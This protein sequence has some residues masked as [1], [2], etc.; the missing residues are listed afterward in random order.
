MAHIY[1]EFSGKKQKTPKAKVLPLTDENLLSIARGV[2]YTPARLR[3][4]M[5]SAS[6]KN[7]V[8]YFFFLEYDL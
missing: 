1:G 3:Q 4:K 7:E 2:G 5:Q 8:V 6:R